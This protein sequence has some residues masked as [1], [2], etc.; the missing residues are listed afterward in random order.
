MADQHYINSGAVNAG[1]SDSNRGRAGLGVTSRIYARGSDSV[2]LEIRVNYGTG[3]TSL[4]IYSRLY[5]R[6]TPN[7]LVIYQKLTHGV[8][9]PSHDILS[10]LY[11]RGQVSHDIKQSIAHGFGSASVGVTHKVYLRD[12]E[13]KTVTIE[14]YIHYGS[15]QTEIPIESKI[16]ERGSV[17]VP[18]KQTVHWGTGQAIAPIEQTVHGIFGQA[19][20]GLTQRV[21]EV[22]Q[23]SH[24]IQQDIN[25]VGFS[26]S[27]GVEQRVFGR[28]ST[29]FG[30]T[31]S[32]V[33]GQGVME[34]ADTRSWVASVTVGGVDYSDRLAGSI[35]VE[36]EENGARIAELYI[37]PESG[38]LNIPQL[39][40]TGVAIDYLD[41]P[42]SED[43]SLYRLFSGRVDTP[44]FDPILNVI[45][46]TCTDALQVKVESKTRENVDAELEGYWHEGLFG[47]YDNMWDYFQ[48]QLSTIPY[49][50]D[51]TIGGA[52]VKTSWTPGAPNFTVTE[53]NIIDNRLSISFNS[54]RDVINH[55]EITAEFRYESFR[56]REQKVIWHLPDNDICDYAANPY[57]LP[58]KET[59]E[60]A[61]EET[62][63]VT[64]NMHFEGFPKWTQCGSLGTGLSYITFSESLVRNM[65][66]NMHMRWSQSAF[67]TYNITVKCPNS[68]A[69]YGKRLDELQIAADYDHDFR[70]W[71]DMDNKDPWN[72]SGVSQLTRII[73]DTGVT[74]DWYFTK[75]T[76]HPIDP[77]DPDDPKPKEDRHWFEDLQLAAIQLEKTK[78]LGSHRDNSVT[79][80][81]PIIPTIERFHTVEVN[82]AR[83]KCRGKVTRTIH[84]LDINGSAET[85]VEVS[86]SRAEG[87]VT[88]RNDE[89][90]TVE[91]IE[92]ELD[93][94]RR[95]TIYLDTHIGGFWTTSNKENAQGA[96]FPTTPADYDD[97]AQ[98]ELT[99]WITNYENAGVTFNLAATIDY[100]DR[101][102]VVELPEIEEEDRQELKVDVDKEIFVYVP[103][104]YLVITS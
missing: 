93:A 97:E 74:G 63:W 10:R 101:R 37:E 47:E 89:I 39:A 13:R 73:T 42:D 49:S 17:S 44:E 19:I 82:T 3:Q 15:G 68:V 78:I 104:D 40:G 12:N 9:F 41:S 38:V 52:G 24:S 34:V 90:E 6:G 76:V 83:V 72:I 103:N 23:V 75:D 60:S 28:G 16:F 57:Y 21:Y 98:D 46:L 4:D 65:T 2:P 35:R 36:A 7:P 43:Y 102:F 18:I 55:A 61:L 30:I 69:Q 29:G 33:S 26:T 32:I 100:Y 92:Y 58:K 51:L 99:G 20:L 84:T 81:S 45:K 56:M 87:N 31:Q 22:G 1:R 59:V 77:P 79:F 8:G 14:H 91:P 86:L 80:A 53:D 95:K 48:D 54:D 5:A 67:E 27:V 71:E 64:D 88:N 96:I 70:E 11:A 66:A 25:K 94:P 62:G 85:E 50:Y